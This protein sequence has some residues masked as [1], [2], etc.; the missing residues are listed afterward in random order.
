M[1]MDEIFLLLKFLS[2]SI[3]PSVLKSKM[4]VLKKLSRVDESNRDTT[5]IHPS[6]S[7]HGRA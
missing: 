3:S 1:S 5:A 2:T 6:N 4:K 7:A